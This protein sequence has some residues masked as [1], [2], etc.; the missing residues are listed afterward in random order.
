MEGTA[1][2]TVVESVVEVMDETQK[3]GT[4]EGTVAEMVDVV[5]KDMSASK[6]RAKHKCPFPDCSSEVIHLPRHMRKI[7]H[8]SKERSKGTLNAFNLRKLKS[9]PP[10]KKARKFKR[11]MCPAKNCNS[12]VKRIHN[13]LTDVHKCIRG[14][15]EYK[16]ALKCAVI[17]DAED[18]IDCEMEETEDSDS[19]EKESLDLEEEL[20]CASKK[21]MPN[22]YPSIFQNVYDDSDEDVE[23]EGV[24]WASVTPVENMDYPHED[25][26]DVID[27]GNNG[28][29]G[30][31]D[32]DHVGDDDGS[33]GENEEDGEH[34]YL[35]GSCDKEPPQL[36]KSSDETIATSNGKESARILSNFKNWLMGPDG[37]RKDDKVASQ[38]K[39]QVQLVA[40]FINPESP[41]INSL[42]SKNVLRDDWLTNFEK[43]K[44]PG[45]LKSYLGTLNQFY[46]YVQSECSDI[47][48][49]LDV[50]QAELV[51]LS[52]QVKLWARS[53][54]KS[55]Q[56]RFWEKRVE[57]LSNRKTPEQIRKFETSETTR[58]AVK[59][60][61]EFSEKEQ[62]LTQAEYTNV[63]DYLLT[64]LCINNGSRSGALANMTLQEFNQASQEEGC[65][66]VRVKNHKTYT[67]HGP[68]NLVLNPTLYKYVEIFITKMR[69][70]IPDVDL[71]NKT[72]VFL[73]WRGCKMDSSHVGG[74]IGSFWSKEFGKAASTGGATSFRKAAVSA[75]HQKNKQIRGDLA[76]LM[77]HNVT[78][79][80][81]FYLLEE[82]GKT[83]VRTSKE[84]SR[85]M[86]DVP[87]THDHCETETQDDV[88]AE[89]P[90]TS[91]AAIVHPRHKWTNDEVGVLRSLF[92]QNIEKKSISLQEVRNVTEGNTVLKNISCSKI[93]DKIRSFF[94][95]AMESSNEDDNESGSDKN[96]RCLPPA[97]KET[98]GQRLKRVGI[99]V[100]SGMCILVIV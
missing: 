12:V 18:V 32:Y 7:H 48:P 96:D 91:C 11:K 29:D 74:Q 51:S 46:I 98:L 82:K 57:D 20:R 58:N 25:D 53:Y 64:E 89:R 28:N 50:T 4:A 52:N 43:L 55:I 26:D 24:N 3:D 95:Q 39:R 100:T 54:R 93:R 14:S 60:L 71:G 36:C 85:I 34:S 37:G 65:Y 47:L 68:V 45:T 99:V 42:M 5:P 1:E 79:A 40:E 49:T 72:T 23:D 77:V 62:V 30:N 17:H 59:L 19:T 35:E 78:T 88:A 81:K 63:R 83:A 87:E 44:K 31:K 80:D 84:L 21:R 22:N 70:N 9:L 6:S 67:T 97:E 66:V 61:G 16:D 94:T 8:W 13:H 90:S 10:E 73:S 56:D 15:T 69:N 27:D 33:Y 86:R 76:S 75:V 38:C 92:S 2:G 41:S